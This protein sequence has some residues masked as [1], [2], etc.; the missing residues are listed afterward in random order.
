MASILDQIL[1]YILG[2]L[3]VSW[4]SCEQAQLLGNGGTNMS[5]TLNV[6]LPNGPPAHDTNEIETELVDV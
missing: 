4:A 6:T 2:F 3:P 1:C 5:T